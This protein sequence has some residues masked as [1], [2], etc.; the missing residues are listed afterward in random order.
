MAEPIHP[1][2]A[3]P[4]VGIQ[5][6]VATPLEDVFRIDVKY[7]FSQYDSQ[8]PFIPDLAR[9]SFYDRED[10]FYERLVEVEHSNHIEYVGDY[11]K[12]RPYSNIDPYGEGLD[13]YSLILPYDGNIEYNISLEF[14]VNGTMLYDQEIFNLYMAHSIW[15]DLQQNWYS[16]TNDGVLAISPIPLCETDQGDLY[17]QRGEWIPNAFPTVKPQREA[18]TFDNYHRQPEDFK[19]GL[20]DWLE[21]IGQKGQ[22][23]KKMAYINATGINGTNI[24]FYSD[25]NI[26]KGM[27][28]KF[29]EIPAYIDAM[30]GAGGNA[31]YGSTGQAVPANSSGM[32]P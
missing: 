22:F 23:L 6:P 16:S 12:Y 4:R 20:M 24:C 2:S 10:I 18:V 14:R 19:K 27:I 3:Y 21:Y 7:D 32:D 29:D 30:D 9:K 1:N 5:I 28:A 26:C 13:N 15:Q 11:E 8:G 31:T 25:P 17:P